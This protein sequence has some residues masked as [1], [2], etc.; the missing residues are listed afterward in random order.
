MVTEV[1]D[2]DDEMQ[3]LLLDGMNVEAVSGIDSE[4][5]KE[6]N[7][8]QDWNEEINDSHCDDEGV[9]RAEYSNNNIITEVQHNDEKER[10]KEKITMKR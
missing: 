8:G 4:P 9:G 6:Y 10:V 7:E 1:Q 2:N 5:G 3:T